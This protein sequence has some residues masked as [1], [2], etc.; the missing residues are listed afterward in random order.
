MSDRIDIL[1]IGA[2]AIYDH[3]Y[4]LSVYPQNGDT[5]TL[6][7]PIESLENTYF[8]DCSANVAAVAAKLGVQAGLAMVVGEDFV[9]T[10]YEQHLHRLQVDLSGVDVRLGQRS[11]H[12]YIYFDGNGDGFCISH[13]GIASEQS[14]WKIPESQIRRASYVVINEKFS[15][16][17]LASARLAK[18]V[19]A[20]VVLNGMVAT[21]GDLAIEF[22][23]L[24]DI[25]FIAESEL[26]NLLQLLKLK[27]PEELV[28]RSLKMV[29]AT[30]GNRGSLVYTP[31]SVE[32]ISPI[33]VDRVVDTTGAGDS[34]A[35]GTLAALSKGFSPFQAAQV[36][37][38]VSSFIIQAWGCQ[39]NLPTWDEMI[40]RLHKYQ[41]QD[42]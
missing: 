13:Q 17:T 42:Q 19:G 24:A 23:G 37:A 31:T 21:A 12:N 32:T 35:A 6:D 30:R 29:F 4:K 26:E 41:E 38:T 5:V 15:P 39:T 7:M 28:S 1:S 18:K 8:G 36:G 2:W 16:Y 20:T 11:G 22:M 10:G 25:L 9:S 40:E 27:S 34:F 33:L 3:L 14:E